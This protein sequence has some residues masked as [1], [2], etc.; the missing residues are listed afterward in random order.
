[1]S[2]QTTRPLRQAM[3]VQTSG[4]L[5]TGQFRNT[6]GGQVVYTSF[7]GIGSNATLIAGSG[8]RLDTVQVM[9]AN[10]GPGIIFYDAPV[11]TSGGPFSTSG[12][13][14][15]YVIPPVYPTALPSGQF[16]LYAVPPFSAPAK[17]G[18]PFYS[19]LVAQAL[20]SGNIPFF[21]TLTP[22]AP[23]SGNVAVN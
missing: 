2:I 14:V 23:I 18:S 13:R 3:F 20:A 12:H 9:V 10:S 11:A 22:E 19:G 6:E 8:G 16:M 15:L 21:V 5:N 7:S 17:C 4:E 1:M